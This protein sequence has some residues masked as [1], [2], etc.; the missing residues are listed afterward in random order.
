MGKGEVRRRK[1]EMLDKNLYHEHS[2]S[3]NG[4]SHS[5]YFLFVAYSLSNN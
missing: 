2:S 1:E 4:K 3:T 5:A